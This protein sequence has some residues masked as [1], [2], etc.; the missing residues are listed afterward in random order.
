MTVCW[1]RICGEEQ[2]KLSIS[3]LPK[4]RRKKF[5]RKQHWTD[6]DYETETLN[7]GVVRYDNEVSKKKIL[8]RLS[9]DSIIEKFHR[10][11]VIVVCRCFRRLKQKLRELITLPQIFLSVSLQLL[12]F[13]RWFIKTSCRT[14]SLKRALCFQDLFT[15]SINAQGVRTI[16]VNKRA[17][18]LLL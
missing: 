16:N 5:Q 14:I 17:D 11:H 9:S 15:F 13:F 1:L 8:T 6:D 18:L 7:V 2:Q 12:F 10:S 3:T 4:W